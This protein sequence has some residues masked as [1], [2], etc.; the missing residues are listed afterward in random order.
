MHQTKAAAAAAS[1]A[2]KAALAAV[3]AKLVDTKKELKSVGPGV[4]CAEACGY[5]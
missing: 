5:C 3:E 2:E 1:A 4:M